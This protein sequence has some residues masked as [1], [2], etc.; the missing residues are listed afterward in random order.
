MLVNRAFKT[1]FQLNKKQIVE[2]SDTEIFPRDFAE[3][4]Q[5]NERKLLAA[6]APVEFEEAVP[7]ERAPHTYLSLR[8][9]L[10][11]S[12]G[13]L[14]G[15][16]AVAVDITERKRL[17]ES[18]RHDK[19]AAELLLHEQEVQARAAAGEKGRMEQV[20]R[21]YEE[22]RTTA[23]RLGR[24]QRLI[25]AVANSLKE[26]L[27][28][29]DRAGLLLFLNSAAERLLG[30]READVREKTSLMQILSPHNAGLENDLAGAITS[31]TACRRDDQTLLRR[32]GHA[33][34]VA[35]SA[36]PL[37]A[38]EQREG[39]V[40]LLQELGPRVG[41]N[42]LEP[43]GNERESEASV[44]SYS[45]RMPEAGEETLDWLSYN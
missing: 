45:V 36:S 38:D 44:L 11:D 37:V 15:T 28:A 20:Q 27:C 34:R 39:A 33:S 1:L 29:V 42:T 13:R 12:A 5:A 8:A 23:E 7:Q 35:F 17:E 24:E 31:G 9:P 22:W 16:C 6:R 18:L 10:Y 14:T 21:L 32:D 19:E 30:C 26:G 41:Y 3:T 2:K 43:T 25:R 4:L 40:L